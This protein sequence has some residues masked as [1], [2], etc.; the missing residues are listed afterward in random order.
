MVNLPYQPLDLQS[1]EIRVLNL[2]WDGR[3]SRP[4]FG[5]LDH[6]SLVDP[7]PYLALSY[8]WGD[9]KNSKSMEISPRPGAAQLQVNIT[10]N[11][12][13]ALLALWNRLEDG[14]THLRIWVDAICI[15]QNDTYERSQ[16]VQ[17][18]RQIYS[19]ATSVVAWV[20]PFDRNMFLKNRDHL[21]DVLADKEYMPLDNTQRRSERWCSL[22]YFFDE[23][24][25]KVSNRHNSI[26]LCQR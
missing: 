7:G 3:Q 11:L 6:V 2:E 10:D 26:W 12:A 8:C 16:Q 20:D 17:V 21:S 18:M 9:R 19:K 22:K 15:N 13:S 5:T 1:F 4:L 23:M 24:Y 14:A 25:W